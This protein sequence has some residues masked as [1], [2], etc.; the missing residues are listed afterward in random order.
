MPP[1]IKNIAQPPPHF[2]KY[3][4]LQEI[5]L[6]LRVYCEARTL[7]MMEGFSVNEKILKII[8]KLFC[9]SIPQYEDQNKFQVVNI[10]K[11]NLLKNYCKQFRRRFWPN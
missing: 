3:K 2:L 5:Y 9:S 11:Q 4:Y 8:N 1:F 10:E 7:V 6:C